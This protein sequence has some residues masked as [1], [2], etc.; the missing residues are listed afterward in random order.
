MKY[1]TA[2]FAWG[3]LVPWSESCLYYKICLVC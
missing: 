3:R 1:A 2:S